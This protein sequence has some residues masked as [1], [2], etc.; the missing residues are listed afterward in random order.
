MDFI[1][2]SLGIL[3]IGAV[4]SLNSLISIVTFANIHTVYCFAMLREMANIPLLLQIQ[5]Y[6]I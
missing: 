6:G 3:I 1:S 4:F 2:I 5:L